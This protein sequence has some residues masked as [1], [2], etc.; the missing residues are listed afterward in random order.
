M[1]K[2]IEKMERRSLIISIV[3]IVLGFFMLIKPD[4]VTYLLL[5][6][7]GFAFVID[8]LLH[9]ISYFT[10]EVENRGFSYEFA[11]AIIYV[12]VGALVAFNTGKLLMYV[13]AIVGLWM[14]LDAIFKLQVSFNV[15][16]YNGTKWGLIILSAIISA[17][18]GVL[19]VIYPR[20]S[21]EAIARMCGGMIIIGEVISLGTTWFSLKG[22][23]SSIAK[24]K[25]IE[26]ESKD[27][28]DLEEQN[29]EDTEPTQTEKISNDSEEI[30]NPYKNLNINDDFYLQNSDKIEND[31][32]LNE[33]KRPLE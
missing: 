18:L 13:A 3:F 26:V 10:T 30:V 1:K 4:T 24:N 32:D 6:F 28:S 14:I 17:A 27:E 19:L 22:F 33:I 8:G 11:Q 16:N 12:A 23:N 7:I 9:F 21:G 29:N 31:N 5:S 2:Y 25:A 15:K 20:E